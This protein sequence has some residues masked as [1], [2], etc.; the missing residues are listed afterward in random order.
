VDYAET[1]RYLEREQGLKPIEI[2]TDFH[3]NWLDNNRA[4]MELG[5]EP[6]YDLPRLIDDAWNYRRAENEP[7]QVFYPG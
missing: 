2:E 7:R 3:S 6:E 1:A 5:W 4:R